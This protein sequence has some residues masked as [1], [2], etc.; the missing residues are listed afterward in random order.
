MMF[1][2]TFTL[3]SQNPCCSSFRRY[4]S[5]F[6]A[7]CSQVAGFSIS[8]YSELFILSWE[9]ELKVNSDLFGLYLE[10]M[11]CNLSVN[12]L[13][14]LSWLLLHLHL[15]TTVSE[16]GWLLKY[17]NKMKNPFLSSILIKQSLWTNILCFMSLKKFWRMD[18]EGN[19]C[20]YLCFGSN[21]NLPLPL[22]MSHR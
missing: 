7:D 16:K 9:A 15:V 10:I 20:I 6:R 13:C 11:G 2:L 22:C 17:Y 8:L 1:S 19:F 3:W 18:A 5:L 21:T 4:G 12:V 14:A